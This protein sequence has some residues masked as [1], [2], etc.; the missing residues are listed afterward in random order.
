MNNDNDKR[1]PC[2]QIY[3]CVCVYIYIYIYDDSV[4]YVSVPLYAITHA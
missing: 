1:N 4:V 3:V 2:W